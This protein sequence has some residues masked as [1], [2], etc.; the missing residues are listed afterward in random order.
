MYQ[1]NK[2]S[3]FNDICRTDCVNIFMHCSKFF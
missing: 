1:L 3:C 2:T